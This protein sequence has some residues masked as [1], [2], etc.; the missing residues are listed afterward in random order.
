MP[1]PAVAIDNLTV[2]Y[3]RRVA[4]DAVSMMSDD[5]RVV[6]VLSPLVGQ[7][8]GEHSGEQRVVASMAIASSP[9][10]EPVAVTL[11]ADVRRSVARRTGE[12]L[13]PALQA[14]TVLGSD[15]HRPILFDLLTGPGHG[16]AARMAA[17]WALPHC[18]GRFTVRLWQQIL[19]RQREAWRRHPTA[20]N[21]SVLRGIAYGVGTDGHPALMTRIEEDAGLP[22]AVRSTVAWVR[23][24]R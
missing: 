2:A 10:R 22:P 3:R 17:A 16:S 21:E 23:D 6:P 20:A 12:D 7:A 18:A 14:L 19:D 9:Y 5:D 4:V 13:S 15:L 8:L 24:H 1:E 11:L